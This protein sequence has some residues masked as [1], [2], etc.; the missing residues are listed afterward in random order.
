MDNEENTFIEIDELR[1]FYR[2][3]IAL[4]EKFKIGDVVKA[5]IRR[6]YTDKGIKI[7]LSRTS[8]KF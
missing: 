7:E 3:K 4:K 6:V 2:E 1:A 5:V 8:P